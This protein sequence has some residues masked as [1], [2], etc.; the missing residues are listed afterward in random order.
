MPACKAVIGTQLQT[1]IIMCT[2][3]TT[4]PLWDHSLFRKRQRRLLNSSESWNPSP[5]KATTMLLIS[6]NA[7]P[8]FTIYSRHIKRINKSAI[9]TVNING[10]TTIFSIS[11]PT[12]PSIFNERCF[13]ISNPLMGICLLLSSHTHPVLHIPTFRV[14]FQLDLRRPIRTISS[15]LNIISAI[16]KLLFRIERNEWDEV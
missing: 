4:V 5:V 12:P 15:V 3:R 11:T 14:Y 13:W 7:M 2:Q 10:L 9:G 6:P 16:A 8:L 1:K